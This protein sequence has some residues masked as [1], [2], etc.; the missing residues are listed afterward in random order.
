VR[1]SP[2][3]VDGTVYV[4]A[5]GKVYALDSDG[6]TEQWSFEPRWSPRS[7]PA[8][9]DGTV[10]VGDEVSLYA[11][12]ADEGTE[13]WSFGTSGIVTSSPAV[14][15]GTVYIGDNKGILYALDAANGVEQWSV[16]IG[17]RVESPAVA[18]GTVYVSD[19]RE[20]QAFDADVGTEQ[21]T[22]DTDGFRPSPAVVDGTVYVGDEIAVYAVDAG[23]G[24]E[25]WRFYIDDHDWSTI[26]R[27]TPVVADGTVYVNSDRRVYALQEGTRTVGSAGILVPGTDVQFWPWEIAAGA[28]GV[29]AVVGVGVAFRR[30]TGRAH[31]PKLIPAVS[32]L[33]SAIFTYFAFTMVST[34][35]LDRV[36]EMEIFHYEN[37][38]QMFGIV[39]VTGAI[40]WGIAGRYRTSRVQA[41][42]IL[43]VVIMTVIGLVQ[44]WGFWKSGI[45]VPLIVTIPTGVGI[46]AVVTKLSANP[47]SDPKEQNGIDII[48]RSLPVVGRRSE[49]EETPRSEPTH[50][51]NS[52]D[53]ATT[54]RP[55]LSLPRPS[56]SRYW[57][58]VGIAFTISIPI[59]LYNTSLGIG[60]L[61]TFVTA[62]AM[63][64]Q[65]E[66]ESDET[67]SG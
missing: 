47:D 15:D 33:L 29:G 32:A 56:V 11:V 28:V 50:Q 43:G 10:Y 9:V 34:S 4:A 5:S 59:G 17:N 25:Q 22:F 26:T 58:V 16:G 48:R 66:E 51:S 24:I 13:R 57:L 20:I 45:I 49:A 44:S 1:L 41:S 21:W 23:N 7:S 6:G 62:Y 60:L 54:G 40:L 31:P 3:V 64:H 27:P 12:D 42:A 19:N 53:A 55:S 30:V 37:F 35:M 8:V 46:L 65:I 2:A 38:P 67:D 63:S 14:V 61:S 36:F 18:D 52:D 39:V